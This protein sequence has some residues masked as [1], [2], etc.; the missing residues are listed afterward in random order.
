MPLCD[1]RHDL[2]D[3]DPIPRPL[4]HL[5][6]FGFTNDV[7]LT[8]HDQVLDY[9]ALDQIVGRYAALLLADGFKNGDRVASWLPKTLSACVL[10]L[11]AAR[12][13]LIYVPINPL[14]KRAQVSH[15]LNDSGATLLV[16]AQARAELLELDD[17]PADCSVLIEAEL[18]SRSLDHE[19]LPLSDQNPDDLAAILYTSGSTGKPKGVM[20]SHANLWLGAVSVA[21]YLK[22][23]RSDNVLCLLPLS[24]D[25]G[26]NQLLSTWAAG[27]SAFPLDYL[28]PKDV[29]RAVKRHDI[30]TI[31]GV[32]PLWNQL[33]EKEWPPETAEKVR[34]LTNSGGALSPQLI[35]AL[36]AQF[37]HADIYPMYG[38]TEAFRSTWLDP[39]LVERHPTSMGTAIPFAEV[40][41][42]KNDG[43]VAGVNEPGELVHTGPLV[44][45]GY[46]R[47][48][49][50]TEERFKAAPARSAYGGMAVWSGDTVYRDENGLHFF[51]GREDEM[52]KVSGNRISPTEIESAAL[53]SNVVREAVAFGVPDDRLGQSITLVVSGNDRDDAKLTAYLKSELPGFMLPTRVIWNENLPHNANGKLDRS[54]V[55][56]EATL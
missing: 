52:I 54:R 5:V 21:H 53:A 6:S 34:R 56:S 46:W 29:I 39:A 28:V 32:P 22:I 38:L 45:K 48:P 23:S 42:V 49:V 44:A 30:T 8:S 41:V 20:L 17:I 40:L 35:N 13:G 31:A 12:A 26:Q 14:L 9:A 15:I 50:R 10:P 7:A 36:R 24:F 11:A 3:I 27:A 47:D 18:F 33:V 16:T 2:P 51:V 19:P 37:P 55:K 43:T 1:E 4:D 25:Y